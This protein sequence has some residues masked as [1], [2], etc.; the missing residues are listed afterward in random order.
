MTQPVADIHP[1]GSAVLRTWWGLAGAAARDVVR[2]WRKLLVL[3][4]ILQG[5]ST[6]ALGPVVAALLA[7]LLARAEFVAVGNTG[8]AEFALSLPGVLAFTLL[9]ILLF[10]IAFVEQSCTLALLDRPSAGVRGAIVRALWRAPALAQLAVRQ[11]LIAVAGFVPLLAIGALVWILLLRDADINFYLARQPPKFLVAV[12]IGVVLALLATAW[13]LWLVLRWFLALPA[14]LLE[15]RTASDAMRASARLVRPMGTTVVGAVVIWLAVRLGAAVAVGVVV[16]VGTPLAIR[17]GGG[18]LHAMILTAGLVLAA[19]SMLAIAAASLDSSVGSALILE[20]FRRATG[21]SGE[22]KAAAQAADLPAASVRRRLLVSVGV[23]IALIAGGAYALHESSD[24]LQRQRVRVVAH[25][26]GAAD[27][28]ENSL[29][30]LSQAI[31][32][33]ADAAEIDVQLSADGTVFVVHDRDL[34]RIAGVPLVISQSHDAELQKVDIGVL[35]GEKWRG[36][37]LAT[38]QQ[39][40]EAADNRI[41]LSIELKYYGPEPRLAGAVVSLIENEKAQTRCEIIS[42]DQNALSQV[43]RIDP[44]IR[45]GFLVSASLGDITRIDADFLSVRQGLFNETL[46]ARARRRGMQLAVW[47]V[48]SREEMLRMMIAGA[49]ELVTDN[50]AIARSA[51][52]DYQSLSDTELLLLRWEQAMK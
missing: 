34:L 46:R 19:H 29:G 10:T 39:F 27:A 9:P 36:Q 13:L 49:D 18:E 15:S 20:T 38:L 32:Q 26:A 6:V 51:V 35:S 52:S 28:P 4:L 21:T 17:I 3:Q 37:H 42:L 48:N 7:A 40:L 8:I 23:L 2:E 14:V 25:R 33:K 22:G 50:P 47:T 5:S 45:L 11:L 44:K 30:A 1:P 41:A 16:A 24:M 12:A 43:K 31:D